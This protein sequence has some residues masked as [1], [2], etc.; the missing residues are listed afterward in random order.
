MRT[1]IRPL[2][3]LGMGMLAVFLAAGPEASGDTGQEPRLA[4][5]A[6]QT[7]AAA[8]PTEGS[9]PAAEGSSCRNPLPW[10]AARSHVGTT[11]ALQGPVVRVML[12]DDLRGK[13]VFI[14]VG[15]PFP[16]RQRLE[17]VIW[18]D[19]RYAFASLLKTRLE[20]REV[21]VSGHVGLRDGV[22]PVVLKAASQLQ[23]AA[24]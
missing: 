17:A 2:V 12:R 22:P 4:P 19:H 20:G 5:A 3:V 1:W 21:C 24:L 16:S 14:S 7:V 13:P 15:Q 18:E 10:Q 23:L 6:G 11:V 9:A 8:T